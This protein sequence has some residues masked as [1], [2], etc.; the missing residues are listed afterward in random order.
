MLTAD[1]HASITY[2]VLFFPLAGQKTSEKSISQMLIPGQRGPSFSRFCMVEIYS[3]RAAVSKVLLHKC[4]MLSKLLL[5][6]Q[7]WENLFAPDLLLCSKT[8]QKMR[9]HMVGRELSRRWEME[10]KDAKRAE[11]RLSLRLLWLEE[12]RLYRMNT[13]AREQ[14]Q[15]QKELEK[16]RQDKYKKKFSS[17][18]NVLLET[19][20]KPEIPILPQQG[21]ERHRTAEP[22]GF[23]T[24][25]HLLQTKEYEISK[26]MEISSSYP[27]ERIKNKEQAFSQSPRASLGDGHKAPKRNSVTVTDPP[28]GRDS[29]Y[30]LRSI[31]ADPQ[32]PEAFSKAEQTPGAPPSESEVIE[33]MEASS[34]RGVGPKPGSN[35]GKW[36]YP[37]GREMPTFVPKTY[38]LYSHLRTVDTMPTYLELFA[39]VKNARYLRHRAPPEFERELS[40]GEIFGHETYL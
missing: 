14:R 4:D 29:I 31:S 18:G 19:Q 7:P 37:P 30:Q 8:T 25:T 21:G 33:I 3:H 20:K 17:F 27:T 26:P 11:A 23:R 9:R 39:K 36:S 2:C 24:E 13:V 12:S 6:I 22:G 15:L 38:T 10:R 28:Q 35:T 5:A 16:L 32:K 34:G 40:I 1:K